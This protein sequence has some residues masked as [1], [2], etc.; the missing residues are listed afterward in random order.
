MSNDNVILPPPL[1]DAMEDLQ[2]YKN[3]MAEWADPQLE[4]KDLLA[5]G[6][7]GRVSCMSAKC[8]P[9]NTR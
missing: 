5:V 9:I 1:S 8:V 3:G 4:G 6:K 2:K 7:G